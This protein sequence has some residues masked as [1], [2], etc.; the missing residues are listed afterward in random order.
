MGE[1]KEL[2]PEAKVAIHEKDWNE[3]RS[4]GHPG[5]RDGDGA[6]EKMAS[7]AISH[8]FPTEE[9]DEV[10]RWIE[11]RQGTPH[12]DGHEEMRPM[13][14][15]DLLLEGGK[16]LSNGTFSLE[17]IHT[18]GHSPGHLCYYEPTKKIMFT[19]DHVLPVI[20]S[21]VSIR[22]GSAASPLEDYLSSLSKVAQ[23]EVRPESAAL[24]RS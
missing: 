21:N 3:A 23:W 20:T 17:T 22:P 14:Q 8:G 5:R 13:A 11:E 12:G 10:A 18:P 4:W 19:G 24:I 9:A 16:R 15:P 2:A 6:L 1:V 7:W